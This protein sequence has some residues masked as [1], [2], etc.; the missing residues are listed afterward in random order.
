[1]GKNRTYLLTSILMMLA[2]LS[3]SPPIAAQE[4]S[5][6]SVAELVDSLGTALTFVWLLLCGGLVFPMHAGFSLVEAGFT[7]T[8]N[9]VNILMKN[10][11]TVCP[12]VRR[13]DPHVDKDWKT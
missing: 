5:I 13:D 8:K 9:T 3:L 11:M 1:M 2:L 10:L 6:K 7:R 4:A 12:G